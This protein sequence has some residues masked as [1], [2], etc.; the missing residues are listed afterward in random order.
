MNANEVLTNVNVYIEAL[1]SKKKESKT[2]R[3]GYRIADVYGYLGIFDWWNESLSLT[4]LKEMRKFLETV[5][6]LGFEGY[7]C[8][9]VGAAGCA[10]GMWAYKKESETGYSPDGEC[11][12]HSFRSGDNYWDYCNDEEK[13]HGD[14][15][16][17]ELKKLVQ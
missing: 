1:E 14:C 6:D 12:F 17:N 4:Q 9:K 8:F 16:L 15:S 3:I 13:W 10:H 11:I 7:V 2:T 5:I